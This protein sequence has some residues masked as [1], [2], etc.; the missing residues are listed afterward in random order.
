MIPL[1]SF[2]IPLFNY[3][4]DMKLPLLIL[5]L[6]SSSLIGQSY[7]FAAHGGGSQKEEFLDF[8]VDDAENSY[9]L[10]KYD[11]DVTFGADSYTNPSKNSL[12][13]QYDK[14][15]NQLMTKD[16]VAETP[17]AI[18]GALGVSGGGVVVAAALTKTGTLDGHEV[19][20]GYFIGKLGNDGNFEW[21]L[22]PIDS[23][24]G[25]RQFLSFRVTAVEVTENEIYVAATANGKITLNGVTDP[26]YA[27]DNETSALLIKM[28]LDGN[29]L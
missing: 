19:Y 8:K 2:E 3:V 5:L 9:V 12:I 15:G 11:S 23:I 13:V 28:D 1:I 27:T 22:Q 20:G 14:D 18:H 6:G 25:A 16:I 10:L 24:E 7:E 26:G 21:V 29:V 17:N 4:A